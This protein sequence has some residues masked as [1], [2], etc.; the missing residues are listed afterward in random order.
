MIRCQ[1]LEY[2]DGQQQAL[3]YVVAPA[4]G[5]RSKPFVQLW[6]DGDLEVPEL[7]SLKYSRGWL[8]DTERN[9]VPKAVRARV[10]VWLRAMKPH[11]STRIQVDSASAGEGEHARGGQGGRGSASGSADTS[12]RGRVRIARVIR[13]A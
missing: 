2:E 4:T 12:S 1:A 11:V 9:E 6:V 7:R 5:G 13:D 3:K 8:I 10:V